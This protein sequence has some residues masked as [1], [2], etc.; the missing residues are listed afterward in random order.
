MTGRVRGRTF[1][2]MRIIG[3][4]MFF[5]SYFLV[6]RIVGFYYVSQGS[7]L[8]NSVVV[9]A[10]S[11]QTPVSVEMLIQKT[12]HP[13][14]MTPVDDRVFFYQFHDLDGIEAF[15]VVGAR[16]VWLGKKISLFSSPWLLVRLKSDTTGV[17]Q[18]SSSLAG[19]IRLWG[20][21]GLLLVDM[22]I[23]GLLVYFLRGWLSLS[24]RVA[25]GGALFL[26]FF[27]LLR[28]FVYLQGWQ[29]K[30]SVWAGWVM[31][32]GIGLGLLW[33]ILSSMKDE[34]LHLR[35][36]LIGWIGVLLFW[37]VN[38]GKVSWFLERLREWREVFY[39]LR[40]GKDAT[41]RRS[42][43]EYGAAYHIGRIIHD[44]LKPVGAIALPG[45]YDDFPVFGN[46]GLMRYFLY[47]YPY[48][49][50]NTREITNSS[51]LESFCER[52]GVEYVL[53]L[54]RGMD[55]FAPWQTWPAFSVSGD[56]LYVFDGER[57]EGALV[58]RAYDP[59]RDLDDPSYM[60]I[61]IRRRP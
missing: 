53:V 43:Y 42:Y 39:D 49:I 3:M 21:M 60:F 6:L 47:P 41:Y 46:G 22:V 1:F 29:M 5:L 10:S 37:N 11:H 48:V 57:G 19:R 27:G 35:H 13:C 4:G 32:L 30:V 12:W 54:K 24:L 44:Y 50:I 61:R 55:S 38:S 8:L 2:W 33:V 23:I 20:T 16:E 58:E 34:K 31:D 26:S 56:G 51:L 15:R 14:M 52:S 28:V 59:E 17:Y 25:M 7:K 18:V 9:V 36:I 40:T 45:Y